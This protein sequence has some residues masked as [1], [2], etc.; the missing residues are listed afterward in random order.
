MSTWSY[1]PNS[2]HIDRILADV[3]TY[4]NIFS[5]TNDMAR[6]S[7]VL[8]EQNT[9]LGR[10]SLNEAHRMSRAIIK[11]MNRSEARERSWYAVDMAIMRS[12]APISYSARWSAKSA[13]LALIAWD[14]ASNYF[15]LSSDEVTV[16][17]I[18]GDNKAI[19][20]LPSIL[21]FEKLKEIE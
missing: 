18:L 8:G 5:T 6:I 15:N 2:D 11:S 1:L 9:T 7:G 17:A 4:P 10:T 14:S 3:K 12:P 21:A 19:L 16:L 13:I 20:M